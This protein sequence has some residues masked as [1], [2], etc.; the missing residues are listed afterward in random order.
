MIL[1]DKK[2]VC[3]LFL[4]SEDITSDD[5]MEQNVPLSHSLLFFNHSMSTLNQ[6]QVKREKE[7]SCA[8]AALSEE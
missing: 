8:S 7:L 6:S 5:E 1:D 3:H 4:T 2:D